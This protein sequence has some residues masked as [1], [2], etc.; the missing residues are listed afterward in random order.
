MKVKLLLTTQ[1]SM[2][3]KRSDAKERKREADASIEGL[4]EKVRKHKLHWEEQRLVYF[5]QGLQNE[6]LGFEDL[7]SQTQ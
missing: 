3:Q 6:L 5:K 4:N 1:E 7:S 2:K